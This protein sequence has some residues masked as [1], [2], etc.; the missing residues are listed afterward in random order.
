MHRN[1]K[2]AV[3]IDQGLLSVG[4]FLT[5]VICARILTRQEFAIF[6]EYWLMVLFT[7]SIVTAAII[8]PMA[9]EFSRIQDNKQKEYLAGI[10]INTF[11]IVSLASLGIA[12]YHYAT[13][14]DSG[15]TSSTALLAGVIAIVGFNINEVARKVMQ[16]QSRVGTLV[17]ASTMTNSLRIISLGA[18]WLTDHLTSETALLCVGAASALGIL[19]LS[20]IIKSAN[21]ASAKYALSINMPSAKWLVPSGLMQWTTI[22]SYLIAVAQSANYSALSE[23]RATQNLATIIN[24]IIQSLE[25][26]QSIQIA[27]TVAQAGY[28]QVH[29]ERLKLF[30]PGIAALAITPL[31][32]G[33]SDQLMQMVYGSQYKNAGNTLTAMWLLQVITLLSIPIR[34][35]LRATGHSKLWFNAYLT[36]SFVATP[37]AIYLAHRGAESIAYSMAGTALAIFAASAIL[38]KYKLAQ[39]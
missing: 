19:P 11:A 22:Y 27:K 36:V 37:A 15:A 14:Y 12:I 6:S 30:A 7:N 32:F 5:T 26:I 8:F 35:T 3:L 38:A 21:Y 18:L 31:I 33:F 16:L 23:L 20:R 25:S 2:I 17:G 1:T 10:F 29:K 4:N 13:R 34:A 24:P 9:S 39:R 28:T